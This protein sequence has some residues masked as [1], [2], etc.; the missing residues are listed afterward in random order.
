MVIDDWYVN[1]H[2]SSPDEEATNMKIV[3]EHFGSV[4]HFGQ[5]QSRNRLLPSQ[6]HGVRER[7]TVEQ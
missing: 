1:H 5:G 2:L 6:S 7:L 4:V 3:F